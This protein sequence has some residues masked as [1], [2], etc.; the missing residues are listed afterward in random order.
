M[1]IAKCGYVYQDAKL[2]GLTKD[3][4]SIVPR[5]VGAEASKANGGNC[6]VPARVLLSKNI[7]TTCRC[8]CAYIS[9]EIREREHP[10]S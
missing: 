6:I 10:S 8:P 4:Y 7:L 9:L 1:T 2:P 3:I 5:C